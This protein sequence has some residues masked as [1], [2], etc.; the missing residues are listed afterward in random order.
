MTAVLLL[1]AK[2]IKLLALGSNG[3]GQ[4][5]IGHRSDT[6]TPHLCKFDKKDIESIGEGDQILKI[7]AGGNHTLVLLQSGA[8]FTAGNNEAGQCYLPPQEAQ[9]S[10]FKRLMLDDLHDA[11]PA[12][13][14]PKI[15]D[16]SATWE[17]SFLLDSKG[18]IFSFGTG[19]RG[20]LGRGDYLTTSNH[21]SPPA[22]AF[23]SE[24]SKFIKLRSGMRHTVAIAEDGE[25]Y[26]WGSCR[27]GELGPDLERQKE[28]R[29]PEKLSIHSRCQEAALGRSFTILSGTAG[30][31]I[32]GQDQALHNLEE[33]NNPSLK[34]IHAGWTTA[35]T[36][37]N[38]RVKAFGSNTRGQHPSDNLPDLSKLA[39]GSEHCLGLTSTGQVVAWGWSEH[40]NCGEPTDPRGN[41]A[42]KSNTLAIPLDEDEAVIDVAAGCATS[43]IVVGVKPP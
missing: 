8:V 26:G 5:G 6:A 33:L 25:V 21:F 9:T 27:K 42:G 39:A 1:M 22:H 10:I 38:Q 12:S 29:S 18:R 19:S 31:E 23:Y 15:V 2:G 30:Y 16:I 40:G 17:A 14:E 7:V 11:D 24:H 34:T 37:V 32:F 20:E 28:V 4:L 43:F 36:L 41:V 3:S 13:G 35:Y